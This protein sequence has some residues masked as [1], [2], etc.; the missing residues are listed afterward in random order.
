MQRGIAELQSH[1]SRTWCLSCLWVHDG[2]L[3]CSNHVLCGSFAG[4]NLLAMMGM[5]LSTRQ[6]GTVSELGVV[7][8]NQGV[9]T[10]LEPRSV[11]GSFKV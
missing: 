5:C 7:P 11:Q 8:R 1:Q 4:F 9:Q 3:D 2:H 6:Q 10:D